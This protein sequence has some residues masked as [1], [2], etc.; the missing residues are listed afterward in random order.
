MNVSGLEG[1]LS[2]FSIRLDFIVSQIRHGRFSGNPFQNAFSSDALFEHIVETD[3]VPKSRF[4]TA[5]ETN[6]VS[7]RVNGF[8]NLLCSGYCFG[9][10]SRH[11]VCCGNPFG[12]TFAFTSFFSA[13]AFRMRSLWASWSEAVFEGHLAKT[14]AL[15]AKEVFGTPC[16]EA[17]RAS[18]YHVFFN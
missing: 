11:T 15:V 13:T 8:R 17:C 5:S 6:L 18:G 9:A 12:C 3:A 1:L 2:L 7:G 4:E 14:V 10:I 16:P